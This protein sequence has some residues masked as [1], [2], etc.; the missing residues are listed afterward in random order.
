MSEYIWIELFLNTLC[1][2]KN[3]FNRI[4]QTLNLILLAKIFLSLCRLLWLNLGVQ[5]EHLTSQLSW[6]TAWLLGTRVS[7]V[8]LADELVVVF[9]AS[10]WLSKMVVLL[11]FFVHGEYDSRPVRSWCYTRE[12][13]WGKTCCITSGGWNNSRISLQELNFR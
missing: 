7:P 13:V 6:V 12:W 3:Q 1:L 2:E 9:Y 11:T 5:G 10:F 8:Y 4:Y